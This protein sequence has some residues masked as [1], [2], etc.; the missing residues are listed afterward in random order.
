MSQSVPNPTPAVVA[1]SQAIVP[2]ASRA[3]PR[4]V[5][6]A[7]LLL[8]AIGVALAA[9]GVVIAGVIIAVIGIAIVM[10][11]SALGAP[12]RLI[13][14]LGG[15]VAD[16]VGD[17][18]LVNVVE[19]LSVANGVGQIEVRVL[20]DDAANAIVVGRTAADA[21]LF[22]TRG[23]L[24]ALD[25]LELEG[26]IAHELA[27]I[28]R[29]DLEAAALVMRSL[30]LRAHLVPQLSAR[31]A[32][33]VGLVGDEREVGADLDA[34]AMTRYPPGLYRA[35][36][37]LEALPTEPHGLE[38]GDRTLTGPFWLVPLRAGARSAG[39]DLRA[40]MAVLAEL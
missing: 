23:L 9:I 22:C 15:R 13:S 8:A 14:V 3:R 30:G 40:R 7:P 12:A 16:P 5:L 26:V 34:V 25:R 1:M 20:E 33:L 2:G 17:A 4:A 21:V 27:H 11:S 39:F 32:R 10:T 31:A 36:E 18:R 19:G 28:K 29:G 35:L 6:Y 24:G 37:K 38:G